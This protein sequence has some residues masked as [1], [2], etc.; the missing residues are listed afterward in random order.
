MKDKIDMGMKAPAV[1]GHC[2]IE[3]FEDGKKIKEIEQDNYVHPKYLGALNKIYSYRAFEFARDRNDLPTKDNTIGTRNGA[4]FVPFRGLV[5]TDA[6]HAEDPENERNIKGNVIGINGI[7]ENNTQQSVFKGRYHIAESEHDL[8]HHKF[9]YEFREEE[10]NGV[11]GSVYTIP[12]GAYRSYA[13]YMDKPRVFAKSVS[14]VPSD[15]GPAFVDDTFV[16]FVYRDKRGTFSTSR[17]YD[18]N[19]YRA[20][21]EELS[22]LGQVE[23]ESVHMPVRPIRGMAEK[24]G[25]IYMWGHLRHSRDTD[26]SGVPTSHSFIV[27]APKNDISN[28]RVEKVWSLTELNSLFGVTVSSSSNLLDQN[29]VA[30]SQGDLIYDPENDTFTMLFRDV[31]T[32]N[33][34]QVPDKALYIFDSDFNLVESKWDPIGTYSANLYDPKTVFVDDK[35]IDMTAN[36]IKDVDPR[37]QL[38]TGI[39]ATPRRG[40]K[41]YNDFFDVYGDGYTLT[42]SPAAH[43]F[44]RVLLTQPINKTNMQTMKI[45]YEFNREP[46]SLDHIDDGSKYTP[47]APEIIQ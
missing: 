46:F 19:I 21:K 3:L 37:I 24:D 13:A 42:F 47:C 20:R 2:K 39:T 22:K 41:K 30:V 36:E 28:V 44:S 17:A 10:A 33:K 11:I 31:E 25:R 1:K 43:F 34:S 18:P 35:I 32:T 23:V 4:E 12:G 7:N 9:V 40:L 15:Y 16:Y 26:I 45:T 14:G 38:N 8:N 27:S 5:L 6:V 29:Y